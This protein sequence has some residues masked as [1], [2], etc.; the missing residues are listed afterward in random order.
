MDSRRYI[1]LYSLNTTDDLPDDFGSN[2][3]KEKFEAGIFLPQDDP[4]WF[5]RIDYPARILLLEDDMLYIAS[6]PS[7][8]ESSIRISFSDLQELEMGRILLLGWLTFRFGGHECHLPYNTRGS[9]PLE[10]FLERLRR[11][12]LN[13]GAFV[14]RENEQDFGESLDLKFRNIRQQDIDRHDDV[15]LQ[16]F[17]ADREVHTRFLLFHLQNWKAGDLV[18]VTPK[19]F[20]WITDRYRGRREFCGGIAHYAPL[21]AIRDISCQSASANHV[22]EL[23]FVNSVKWKIPVYEDLVLA[24][25]EFADAVRTAFKFSVAQTPRSVD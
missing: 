8:G 10:E 6:H 5:G 1:F 14:F 4:D 7:S 19:C 11:K 23:L 2:L 15:L 24:A 25:Q 21:S 22:M 3:R 13:R 16:F 18:A 20:V 9:R 17:E 12:W